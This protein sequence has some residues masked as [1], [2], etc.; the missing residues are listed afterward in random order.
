LFQTGIDLLSQHKITSEQALDRF[1]FIEQTVGAD[2]KILDSQATN[3]SS[4]ALR[5]SRKMDFPYPLLYSFIV[6]PKPLRDVVYD[7][8]AKYRYR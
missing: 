3:A 7:L 2:E 8:C 4:A 5:I 6:I 1:V